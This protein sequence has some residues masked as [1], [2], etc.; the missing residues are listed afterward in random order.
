MTLTE[1][2][3][4]L[5]RQIAEEQDRAL[6][7]DVSLGAVRARLTRSEKRRSGLL[8]A[9]GIGVAGV[10]L[11]AA[12][13]G[14]V[15][16]LPRGSDP[17]EARVGGVEAEVGRWVS[18][19]ESA[20]VPLEFSDGTRIVLQGGSRARLSAV[21]S[22][23]A[24]LVIESGS[25]DVDVVSRKK[26]RWRLSVGPFAVDVTGTRF[27]IAWNPNSE[28]LTIGMK[29]GNVIVSGCVL[30]DGRALLAG[31]KLSASCRD[32]RFEIARSNGKSIEATMDD[33]V[34]REPEPTGALAGTGEREAA[35]PAP[36]PGPAGGTEVSWQ[37]LARAGKYRDAFATASRIGLASEMARANGEELSMLGDSAR[38]SG[39]SGEAIRIFLALRNRFPKSERASRAA[40]SIARVHFDHRGAYAEAARWFQ[41]YLSE[42]RGGPFARE[43]L[44]RLM[45]SLERSGD[46][47]GA[48]TVA[49]R[50]LAKYPSG[51]HERVA[52]QL[53]SAR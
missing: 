26:S 7:D 31:E 53:Q 49:E 16:M 25:A 50:Y 44:G 34:V 20:S 38:F 24:H 29:E 8:R 37:E 48:R 14:A 32:K 11:A 35:R 28:L 46:R 23:G 6:L 51:P 12:A 9:A 19:P 40:F 4:V 10:A 2:I 5:G 27:D 21:D 36:S 42:Q 22:E 52:R 39:N 41:T 3:E 13:A 47:A 43:A 15:L 45:E 18:A 33:L 1:P 30:G 17:L